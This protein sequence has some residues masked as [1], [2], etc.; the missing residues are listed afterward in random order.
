[1]DPKLTWIVAAG[2]CCIL[3]AL[4]SSLGPSSIGDS[5]TILRYSGCIVLALIGFGCASTSLWGLSTSVKW[6]GGSIGAFL[7][8]H[9]P[10]LIVLGLLRGRSIDDPG[11]LIVLNW[12]PF[13]FLGLAM[14]GAMGGAIYAV[15]ALLRGAADPIRVWGILLLCVA[16]MQFGW[17]FLKGFHYGFT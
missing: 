15:V 10:L 8:F 6:I 4:L 12:L 11:Y 9:R 1:M 2:V 7:L 14:L 5:T 17:C 13:V 3:V 16:G